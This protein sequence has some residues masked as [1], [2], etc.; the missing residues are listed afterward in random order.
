MKKV[1]K[2]V[3][4]LPLLL[5]VSCNKNTDT[6][7][8]V[9]TSS[10]STTSSS[11]SSSS[12]S[13]NK[14]DD[15]VVLYTN[16]VH[17]QVSS[18]SSAAGYANVAAK[19]K[20]LLSEYNNVALVDSGDELQGDVYGSLTKGEAIVDV[21]NTAGYDFA[22]I[23]NHE[24]DF[25]MDQFLKL[26]GKNDTYNQTSSNIRAKYQY[27]S[28]NFVHNEERV[29]DSYAI[30]TF[31]DKKVA[32][33][34][35]T[36]PDTYTSS[37]PAY[38]KDDTG[39]YVYNFSEGTSR[40]DPSPFY[41]AI[42]TEVDKAK[43]AGADYVVLLAHL[44]VDDVNSPYRST[45]VISKTNNI[46]VVLDAHSHSVIESETYKNKDSKDV[47]LSSTGTKLANLG[48]LTISNGKIQTKLIPAS[49]LTSEDNDTKAVVEKYD[50]E[51]S[52][53][54]S[55]KLGATDFDLTIKD[56]ATGNRRVRKAETNLGNLVA[57]AYADFDSSADF[58]IVNGGGVRA[59]VAIGD[60]QY[61]DAIS[62]SPFGNKLCTYKTTG[63]VIMEMLEYSVSTLKKTTSGG[64]TLDD[65]SDEFGGFLQPSSKLHFE[66][67]TSIEP[68]LNYDANNKPTS[69]KT[70]ASERRVKNITI[71]GVAIEETKEY[72]FVS[73][74]YTIDSG[75][76]GYYMFKT[77]GSDINITDVTPSSI[78]T[79]IDNDVLANFI[80]KICAANSGKIPT[81]YS[82]LAGDGRITYT[83]K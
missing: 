48:Q 35:A 4:L 56:S 78:T 83:T 75:G 1:K 29:F 68:G 19:K 15:V 31:G 77:K 39:N 49:E 30:K 66:V 25:G 79:T 72:K 62:I 46:D 47:V 33:V 38:F 52:E 12:S 5:L 73:N 18:S 70:N 13:S 82:N 6:S 69:L 65:V 43:T 2:V 61:K 23:G 54:L 60:I 42:Q 34:G 17:C 57:D 55:E 81:T 71:N 9:S 14:K 50:D 64:I 24:F 58:A 36:T 59:N 63:K 74:N 40:S 80:K 27:L 41:N 7:T 67:D 22:T 21:M 10:T 28:S 11:S 32:F 53:V 45:D 44:G 26:A 37:T 51:F 76:D 20:A 3:S 8:S 16:D